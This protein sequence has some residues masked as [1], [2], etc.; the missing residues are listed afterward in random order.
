MSPRPPTP[1]QHANELVARPLLLSAHCVRA[2]DEQPW[3]ADRD[4]VG[5]S[6]VGLPVEHGQVRNAV[7]LARCVVALHSTSR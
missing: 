1:S 5:T 6:K 2:E 7:H 3:A 4:L